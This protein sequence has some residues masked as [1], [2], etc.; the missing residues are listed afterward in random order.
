MMNT[1]E[2]T[3][4]IDSEIES[5]R[6]VNSIINV[7]NCSNFDTTKVNTINSK[8]FVENIESTSDVL[9]EDNNVKVFYF[10]AIL[11]F[12]KLRLAS[13]MEWILNYR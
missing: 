13:I 2:D 3:I 6:L 5:L 1:V 11:N 10:S 9:E 4:I 8:Y 7:D 12:I